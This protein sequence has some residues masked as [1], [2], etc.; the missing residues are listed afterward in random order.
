MGLRGPPG[1]D[2]KPGAP[3]IVAYTPFRV[4]SSAASIDTNDL[5]IP[6]SIAAG[7]FSIVCELLPSPAAAR[8]Y[9]GNGEAHLA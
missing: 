1:Q 4:N 9:P 6:P 7:E 2:G 5:L 3:S 8:I